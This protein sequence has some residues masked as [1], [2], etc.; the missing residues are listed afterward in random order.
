MGPS[1]VA[2]APSR[3][4]HGIDDGMTDV[5]PCGIMKAS[6]AN[7]PA[8][9]V[10]VSVRDATLRAAERYARRQKLTRSAVVQQALDEFLT[11]RDERRMT[12]AVNA[13]LGRAGEGAG[14]DPAI[15]RA[16]RSAVR[17]SEWT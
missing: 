11:R 17:R 12:E 14:L 15:G 10:A 5:I 2:A 16:G 1:F 3:C 6:P 13:S 8:R 4:G 7:T 9:K